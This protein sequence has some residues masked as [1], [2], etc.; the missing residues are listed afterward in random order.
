L[1]KCSRSKG[2]AKPVLGFEI[3]KRNEYKKESA[4]FYESIRS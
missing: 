3:P 4:I 1:F 2:K